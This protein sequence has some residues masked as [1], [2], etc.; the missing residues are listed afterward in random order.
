MAPA[1]LKLRPY[2]AIQICLLLLLLLLLL[3]AH[4]HKACRQLIFKNLGRSSRGGGQKLILEIITM[5]VNHPSGSHIIII[6]MRLPT[7]EIA[8]SSSVQQTCRE[9]ALLSSSTSAACTVRS[10]RTRCVSCTCG[11]RTRVRSA[12]RRRQVHRQRALC[13][14]CPSTSSQSTSRRCDMFTSLLSSP[15]IY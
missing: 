13:V 11:W 10:T 7:L 12:S 1:P 2:G 9:Q 14:P 15:N 6:P 3:L 4:Q 8:N 5:M